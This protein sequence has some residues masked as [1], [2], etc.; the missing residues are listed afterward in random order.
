MTKNTNIEFC[1]KPRCIVLIK[2]QRPWTHH[3]IRK[4][5]ITY[6]VIDIYAL[7]IIKERGYSGLTKYLSK[8]IGKYNARVI[9]YA[10][11]FFYGV[12]QQFIKN[13]KNSVPS[14][15]LTFDDL[16]LHPFNSITAEACDLVLTADPKSVLMYR[17]KHIPA[18]FLPLEASG[19]IYY[20][21]HQKRSIDV[22]FFG[23]IDL[24]D[25]RDYI[26]YLRSNKIDITIVGNGSNYVDAEE[27]GKII[28]QAK[29]VINFS[30]TGSVSSSRHEVKLPQGQLL[31]IK[32]RIIESALCNTVCISEYAPGIDLLFT[33]DEVPLFQTK[34]ECLTL[35]NCLLSNDVLRS[36]YAERV[37]KRARSEY[38]DNVRMGIV[39]DAIDALIVDQKS[40]SRKVPVLP[41]WYQQL[42][43]RSRIQHQSTTFKS[44]LQEVSSVF[45]TNKNIRI[46][47][48]LSIMV[49]L[50][51]WVPYHLL[52]SR[53]GKR[54]K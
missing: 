29:L 30:K 52:R 54:A 32:G 9:I 24:A 18:E 37:S 11:D 48:K 16:T 44:V 25:R 28:S 19:D 35:I 36:G 38:E 3:I 2:S 42:V 45:L 27:L 39:K 46:V 8:T 26:E 14:V 41:F 33:E 34:E 20:E 47:T 15:L 13:I 50:M 31:Q 7:P 22:L 12:D 53:I 40:I 10:V 43:S 6:D 4:F 1:S 5:S 49:D 21:R 23:N 17:E 51:L